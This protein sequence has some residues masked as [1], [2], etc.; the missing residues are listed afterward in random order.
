MT[1]IEFTGLNE[2]AS[3]EEKIGEL[4]NNVNSFQ[5]RMDFPDSDRGDI[6]S[7]INKCGLSS[8]PNKRAEFRSDVV[9]GFLKGERAVLVSCRGS[10][11][12]VLYFKLKNAGYR[13]SNG[14][15]VF[16]H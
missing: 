1:K 3:S 7:L 16:V 11:L 6:L 4:K 10:T 13:L 12:N 15:G 9:N 2:M 14:G 5:F 8:K